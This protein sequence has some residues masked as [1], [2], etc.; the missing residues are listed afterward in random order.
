MSKPVIVF[1]LDD[2][3]LDTGPCFNAAIDLFIDRM[4]EHFGDAVEA[5]EVRRV[6]EE[7]DVPSSPGGG[8]D[9]TRFPRSFVATYHH[10]CRAEG[11]EPNAEAERSWYDLGWEAFNKVPE[12]YA[13]AVEVLESLRDRAE[14]RLYTLGVETT[15]GKKIRA[16]R[17]DRF[18]ARTHVVARK[19]ASALA[20]AASDA[21]AG[22]VA[23]VGDSIRYEINPALELG[24]FAVHIAKPNP[25]KH[26]IV[27]PLSDAFHSAS[28]LTEARAILEEHF[29][30]GVPAAARG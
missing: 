7:S 4:T 18:F 30:P 1:D 21:P 12:I 10:F 5:E 27:D 15:Q 23:V 13:D 8:F 24:F 26:M 19:D 29:L 3:L 17:L 9:P 2:T 14:L 20:S 6:Q 11:V 28:N 25:W 16:H 22:R